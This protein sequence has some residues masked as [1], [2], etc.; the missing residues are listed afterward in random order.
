L[1]H[2][3]FE[4]DFKKVEKIVKVEWI[5]KIL[6]TLMH[7]NAIMHLKINQEVSAMRTTIELSDFHRSVLYQ[8]SLKRGWRGYSKIIQ[9]AIDFYLVYKEKSKEER[10]EILKLKGT[11][12]DEEA[13]QMRTQIKEVRNNWRE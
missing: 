11:F 3:P 12:S 8:L 10:L 7:S 13:A 6:L 9:E 2:N 5:N 1:R 4:P